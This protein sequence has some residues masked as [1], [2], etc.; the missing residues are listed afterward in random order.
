MCIRDRVTCALSFAVV[1]EHFDFVPGLERPARRM[2]CTQRTLGEQTQLAGAAAQDHRAQAGL[3]AAR[4]RE[5]DATVFQ[6]HGADQLSSA[7]GSP[8]EARPLRST[9]TMRWRSTDWISNDS[10]P[11]DQRSPTR[12][13]R[14]MK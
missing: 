6:Q 14:P 10:G 13:T 2:L 7:A 4:D 3:A 5:N 12:G 1:V 9:R 11:Y 8:M